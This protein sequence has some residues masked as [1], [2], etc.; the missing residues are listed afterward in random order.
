MEGEGKTIKS[1]CCSDV[2]KIRFQFDSL[3]PVCCFDSSVNTQTLHFNEELKEGKQPIYIALP[4]KG[5]IC[6]SVLKGPWIRR[7]SIARCCL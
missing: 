2:S 4:E 1:K 7:L 5:F 3:L 6:L